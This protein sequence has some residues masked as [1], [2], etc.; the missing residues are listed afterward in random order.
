VSDREAQDRRP[1]IDWWLAERVAVGMAGGG[2]GKRSVRQA[3]VDAAAG[4]SAEAVTGYTGLVPRAELPAPEVVDR[5]EWIAANLT[6]LRSA[7]AGIE[8]T[9]G[10]PFGGPVGGF[11]RTLAGMGA[12]VELGLASG[13]LA[14]RVL[15]QYDVAL[16]GPARP[17]RLLFVA[18]N[19]AAAHARLG[20]RR[21]LFL[22]W[23]ALHEG[24]HAVQFSAVPWLR[25]HI[26]GLV[27]GILE[28]AGLRFS[29]AGVRRVAGRLLRDPAGVAAGL[30]SGDLAS[31]VVSP[32]RRGLLRKLA[33]TMTIV[34]GYSEHVMDAVGAGV[35]PDYAELRRRTD[36]E[37]ERRG[38]LDAVV[39]RLLGL[40]L[41]LRQYRVGKSFA[42]RVVEEQ[43]VEALNRV[44]SDPGSLPRPSELERPRR[45]LAR[46][47]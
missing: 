34:E 13:Y 17:A 27:E 26:G 44:W 6:S 20:G 25:S 9:M 33:A 47:G 10:E 29:A 8:R 23:I 7:S 43:G 16:I 18:P 38:L 32:R 45:W 35:D 42:D 2:S 21:A 15:G 36:R 19:L 3:D 37:R 40:E 4:R 41:K 46:V 12:G 22:R 1:V 30:R 24:T 11:V 28:G 14:Q 5:P 39:F 31:L